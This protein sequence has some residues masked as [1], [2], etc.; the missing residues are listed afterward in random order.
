MALMERRTDHRPWGLILG[1]TIAATAGLLSLPLQV[2]T[3]Q[4]LNAASKADL[5]RNA[6]LVEQVRML[7]EQG[8]AD[9][10]EHRE[11]N[12]L[13]HSCIVDLALSLADP[14]RDR[15]KPIMN[16][17]PPPIDAGG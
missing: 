16:P 2:L 17:C 10:R 3:F 11:R 8:N 4:G 15:T 12:E 5:E 6:R 14:K 9:V 7:E 1:L 13:L